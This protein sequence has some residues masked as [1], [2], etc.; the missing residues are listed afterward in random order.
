MHRFLLMYTMGG[1]KFG[2]NGPKKGFS[3]QNCLKTA[4]LRDTNLDHLTLGCSTHNLKIKDFSHVFWKIWDISFQMSHRQT[5]LDQNC[6]IGG[7]LII[8][9]R[10]TKKCKKIVCFLRLGN[11]LEF[12]IEQHLFYFCKKLHY[13]FWYWN[14]YPEYHHVKAHVLTIPEQ[15]YFLGLGVFKVE[16]L[17]RKVSKA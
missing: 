14:P 3:P 2:R 9:Q 13:S 15:C 17:L 6:P 4:F 7:Y 11:F 10:D 5:F 8:L 16:L 12:F 1:G